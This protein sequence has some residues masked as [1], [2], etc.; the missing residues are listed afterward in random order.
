MLR[1]L[2]KTISFPIYAFIRA[3]SVKGLF[4]AFIIIIITSSTFVFQAQAAS[5]YR[6]R[7]ELISDFLILAQQNP[8][9]ISTQIIGHSVRNV[10]IYMFLVGNPS[11]ESRI[12]ID[13][14]RHGDEYVNS[15]ALYSVTQWLLANATLMRNNL[16]MIIPIVN[17]DNYAIDRV[18]ANN[19]D[20]NRN[21]EAFWST[22]SATNKG[23]YS[24]SEPESQAIEELFKTSLSWYITLHVGEYNTRGAKVEGQNWDAT[25]YREANTRTIAIAG[26]FGVSPVPY[27][28]AWN[29]ATGG[30]CTDAWYS[31]NIPAFIVEMSV[32]K[33]PSLSYVQT[34]LTKQILAI[35]I[36]VSTIDKSSV[37]VYTLSVTNVGSGSVTKNP[38]LGSYESGAVTT[39]IAT[40]VDGWSF[41]GW[42]GD[43]TGNTNPTTIT[44][45]RDKAV[46]ATFNPNKYTLSI[47][48]IG[49]GS[50]S[51]SPEQAFYASD[52]VVT[53]T[54]DAD[55]GWSFAGWSG[56]LES[57][58]N[59]ETIPIDGDKTVTATFELDLHMYE[60]T[61]LTTG[62][63]AGSI[64]IDPPGPTYASGTVV[65]VTAVATSGSFTGWSG[66]LT[67]NAN[68]TTIS[69]I[70]NKTITAT[71]KR[72]GGGSGGSLNFTLSI[73][74]VGT[75]S[76]SIELSP[77]ESS[78]YPGTEVNITAIPDTGSLFSGWNGDASGSANLIKITMDLD[79]SINA[80]FT[81]IMYPLEI[82]KIGN[83]SVTK[84][85]DQDSYIISNS[86]RLT[87][88]PA[89]GWVFNAWSGDASGNTTSLFITMDRPKSI[90]ATFKQ[91]FE[92][93]PGSQEINGTTNK[94][95][96]FLL[97]GAPV[98]LSEKILKQ[99][100]VYEISF[101]T[102]ADYIFSGWEVI[103]DLTL[104]DPNVNPTLVNVRGSG[105]ITAIFQVSRA[106]L[107]IIVNDPKGKALRGVFVVSILQPPNQVNLNKK[108]DVNGTVYYASILTG[109]YQIK[110][111]KDGYSLLKSDWLHTK[112]MVM[113]FILS[114]PNATVVVYVT[115]SNGS[116]LGNV[117][118]S[119]IKEPL[120]QDPLLSITDAKGM[121]RFNQINIGDYSLLTAVSGYNSQSVEF[122]VS[123]N[124]ETTKSILLTRLEGASSTTDIG[125]LSDVTILI[126]G[127]VLFTIGAIVIVAYNYGILKIPFFKNR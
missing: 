6:T 90:S 45:D 18:N 7:E 87:A 38:D 75:G 92:I 31:H 65:T 40:S 15:E 1:L 39:L 9:Y 61:T 119:S 48:N 14:E 23:A 20:L 27:K 17:P 115:D 108:T 3:L 59:P 97:D 98:N 24:L 19:I 100:R 41:A 120:G 51:M 64:T 66:D 47:L 56:D 32:N 93:I 25:A 53:L 67:G 30:A 34:T 78:Y 96:S 118:V 26:D 124:I 33:T 28:D 58:I 123:Q 16:Y 71:F 88:V 79:K 126:I 117:K 10:P 77:L 21:F 84:D 72:S 60:L 99:S 85:P 81:K 86:V 22:T 8:A 82:L 107:T 89:A 49:S 114:R 106:D 95:G 69:M 102:P 2:P 73:N 54:A 44:I 50:V 52:T 125:K 110:V 103:G 42:S 94:L 76:G 55:P 36:G 68:P 29:S 116:P 37:E 104:E 121:V 46:I 83:G 74:I 101:I 80:T 122:T 109:K 111:E 12:L 11:S 127:A 113:R 35:I 4:L 112:G 91:L 70:S 13:G 63:G 57:S 5:I 105:K 62:T 43:L